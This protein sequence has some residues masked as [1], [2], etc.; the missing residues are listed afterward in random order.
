MMEQD[1]DLKDTVDNEQTEETQEQVDATPEI[2]NAEETTKSPRIP[3]KRVSRANQNP[4]R[5]YP[6]GGFVVVGSVNPTWI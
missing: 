5:P 1:K 2:N 3:R 6:S 4:R